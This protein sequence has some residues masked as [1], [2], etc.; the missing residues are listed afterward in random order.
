MFRPPPKKKEPPQTSI[1]TVA[2]APALKIARK[3]SVSYWPERGKY[4]VGSADLN[5]FEEILARLD[6]KSVGSSLAQTAAYQ[7]A[8]PLFHTG[9]LEFFLRI[10]PLNDFPSA[11][12]P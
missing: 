8:Q 6:G 2:G 1:I 7:E 11:L 10:P 5:V 4:A 9:L 3:D 12:P